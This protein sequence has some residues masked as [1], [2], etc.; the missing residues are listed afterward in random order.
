MMSTVFCQFYF[1]K[2]S[3]CKFEIFV[4]SFITIQKP[5]W[6]KRHPY[7]GG[8]RTPG[9]ALRIR[10][11]NFI[12]SSFQLQKRIKWVTT[13]SHMMK[14]S[15]HFKFPAPGGNQ[16]NNDTL[17]QLP[18]APA[19]SGVPPSLLLHLLEV[20]GSFD[21]GTSVL[22]LLSCRISQTLVTKGSFSCR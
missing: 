3:L 19:T 2:F 20:N 21:V 11:E 7:E 1:L 8:G 22:R 9:M 18:L 5:I 13:W 4:K 15:S 12:Y 10:R 14:L 16:T 17:Q 6:L